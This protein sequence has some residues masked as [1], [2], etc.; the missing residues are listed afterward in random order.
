MQPLIK[1]P[2]ILVAM[3][4]LHITVTPPHPPPTEEE[5]AASTGLEVV[6]K[7]RSGATIV[8][9]ICWGTA[10]AEVAVILANYAPSLPIS[11]ALLS[12]LTSTYDSMDRIHPSPLFFVGCFL[13]AFGGFIRYNCYKALGSMF[14]FEMS[15]RKDHALVTSGPY[16]I[17]R[18]PGYTGVLITLTGMLLMHGAEVDDGF[19]LRLTV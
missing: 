3:V 17:V 12:T 1:I 19:V 4:G 13:T 7:R 16:S 8:R 6:I 14:T 18:H 10:L 2:C 15:I 11:R 5:K 9:T